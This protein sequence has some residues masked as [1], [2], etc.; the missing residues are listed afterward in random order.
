MEI[1]PFY[2]RRLSCPIH[3]VVSALPSI[4]RTTSAFPHHGTS[5]ASSIKGNTDEFTLQDS[6]CDDVSMSSGPSNQDSFSHC[7]LDLEAW[8]WMRLMRRNLGDNTT[9][10]A[11]NPAEA[12]Q[13]PPLAHTPPQEPPKDPP[14]PR[15]QH[16]TTTNQEPTSHRQSPQSHLT[17]HNRAQHSAFCPDQLSTSPTN[18]GSIATGP[19]APPTS[20][21]THTA[22]DAMKSWQAPSQAEPKK[23]TPKRDVAA[24]WHDLGTLPHSPSACEDP[25]SERTAHAS[26]SKVHPSSARR[27]GKWWC[28][29]CKDGKGS[30]R[31]K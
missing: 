30:C 17:S 1:D 8:T 6:E 21:H 2:D 12:Q 31:V 28:R 22:F 13:P 19:T 25:D 11:S 20:E 3:N 5:V 14:L 15:H 10:P 27:K 23:P 9:S 16:N 29:S 18:P 26:W 7:S 4:S 24:L